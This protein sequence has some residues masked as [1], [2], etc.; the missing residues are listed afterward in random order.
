MMPRNVPLAVLWRLALLAAVSAVVLAIGIYRYDWRPIGPKKTVETAD[1]VGVAI[2][3]H[4][5]EEEAQRRTQEEM[6]PEATP[7]PTPEA[8]PE[9]TPEA[10]PE[11][12]PTPTPKPKPTPTPKPKPKPTPT[13]A[14][15]EDGLEDFLD[16]L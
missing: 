5:K 12:K 1:E 14:L 15:D 3:Q 8:T 13:P 4:F 6:T 10:T 11:D 2:D 7:K 16:N 9:P